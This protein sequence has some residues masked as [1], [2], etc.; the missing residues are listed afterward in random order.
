VGETKHK[1]GKVET[2][3]VEE[4]NDDLLVGGA[5]SSLHSGKQRTG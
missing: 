4:M 1:E 2:D 3:D 5:E